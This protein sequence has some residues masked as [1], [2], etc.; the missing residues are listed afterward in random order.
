M[1]L[2]VAMSEIL[3]H[4]PFQ[5]DHP[6]ILDDILFLLSLFSMGDLP[7]IFLLF[8]LNAEVVSCAE[9]RLDLFDFFLGHEPNSAI[10]V[11]MGFSI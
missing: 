1:A 5:H 6:I 10:Q 9:V 11:I 3:L 7:S 4:D 2:N 8:L